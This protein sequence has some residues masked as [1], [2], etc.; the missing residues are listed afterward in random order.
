MSFS[1]L[2]VQQERIVGTFSINEYLLHSFQ[3]KEKF[4]LLCLSLYYTMGIYI[5]F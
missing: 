3:C 1:G 4:K 5:N 2:S